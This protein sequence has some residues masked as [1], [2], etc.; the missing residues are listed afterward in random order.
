MAKTIKIWS[1]RN[2]P[3]R[4]AFWQLERDCIEATIQGWIKIYRDD[5]PEVIFLGS[6]RKPA[7]Y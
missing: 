2:S 3:A 5:E 1:R 7:E 6:A 4:G